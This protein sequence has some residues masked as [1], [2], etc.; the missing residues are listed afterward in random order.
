VAIKDKLPK[1]SVFEA[2]SVMQKEIMRGVN[3][4]VVHKNAAARKIS[5][6]HKRIKAAVGA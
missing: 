6:M 3:K 4:R 5:R 1:E 2:F